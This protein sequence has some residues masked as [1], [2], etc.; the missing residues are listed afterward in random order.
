MSEKD[1]RNWF[2]NIENYLTENDCRK[3]LDYPSR[4]FNGDKTC[5]MLCPKGSKV[6]APRGARNIYEVD[7][8]QAKASLTVMFTFGAN[9]NVTPPM[10]IYPNKRRSSEITRSLPDDWGYGFSDSGWMK[11]ECFYEYVG[12]ILFPHLKNNGTVFPINKRCLNEN[13]I[14]HR[15]GLYPW[16]SEAI[17]NFKCLGKCEPVVNINQEVNGEDLESNILKF[18]AF[19]EIVSDE[20]TGE[21][22]NN[23]GNEISKYFKI[24]CHI[25]NWA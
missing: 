24:L 2:A 6:L 3:T 23:V 18:S 17:N 22:R 8:G 15:F 10:I 11:A 20:V 1:I 13:I 5:F 9:G 7:I 19:K 4:V 16:N 14:K 12:N 25:W 21:L